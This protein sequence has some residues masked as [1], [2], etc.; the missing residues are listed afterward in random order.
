MFALDTNAIIHY[1]QQKGRVAE[2]LR[3]VSLRD[4]GVPAIVQYELEVGATQSQHAAKRRKDIDALL[5]VVQVLEFNSK[6]AVAASIVR[7]KLEAR[8]AMIGSIDFLVAGTAIAHG[9]TLVTHNTAEFKRVPGLKIV[10]W[11]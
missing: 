8:G 3:N 4:I 11:Y 7:S 1:F 5:R 10:D 9:A 6:A 2:R